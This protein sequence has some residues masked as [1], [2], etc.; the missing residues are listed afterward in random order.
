V[1]VRAHVSDQRWAV[2]CAVAPD[3][4]PSQV[5]QKGLLALVESSQPVEPR[6]LADSVTE[7]RRRLNRMA[8]AAYSR[9]WEAGLGLAGWIAWTDLDALA[10]RAWPEAEIECHRQARALVERERA[11]PIASTVVFRT[12][13]RD[14]LAMAWNEA[15]ALAREP[16]LAS[17]G[18][19]VTDRVS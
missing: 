15:S 2:A 12:G 14:A 19:A 11:D 1:R 5:L 8:D 7:G 4:S 9:G 6:A 13:C 3:S 10:G 17:A 16:Y 18:T